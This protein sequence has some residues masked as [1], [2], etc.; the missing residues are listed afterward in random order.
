MSLRQWKEIQGL[1]RKVESIF[2]SFHISIK[3]RE[4]A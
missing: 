3:K 4:A 2:K 1:L